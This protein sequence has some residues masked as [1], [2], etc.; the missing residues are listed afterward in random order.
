MTIR[1]EVKKELKNIKEERCRHNTTYR[2]IKSNVPTDNSKNDKDSNSIFVT[3]DSS[4][5]EG[6]LVGANKT[7]RSKRRKVSGKMAKPSLFS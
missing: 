3:P 4:E 1:E 6:K 2:K 7:N 5:D